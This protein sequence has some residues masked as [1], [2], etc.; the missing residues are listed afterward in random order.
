M[1]RDP[2]KSDWTRVGAAL[3]RVLGDIHFIFDCISKPNRTGEVGL[4]ALGLAVALS[5]RRHR[6]NGQA[7]AARPNAKAMTS[8]DPTTG[9]AKQMPGTTLV[10]VTGEVI[11]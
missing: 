3:P 11:S 5:R 4:R 6:G 1:R 9:T 8:V 7:L 2:A 10:N